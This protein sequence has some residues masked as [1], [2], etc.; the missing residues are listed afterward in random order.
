GHSLYLYDDEQRKDAYELTEK[1]KKDHI[2]AL[3]LP[4]LLLG[5]ML[6]NQLME[7]EHVPSLVLIGSEAVPEKLWSR[8]KAYPQLLVEN[9]YGPTEFTVDA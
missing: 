7:A 2:D 9:F 3:D 8:V 4:P 5:Q 6:D 1:V